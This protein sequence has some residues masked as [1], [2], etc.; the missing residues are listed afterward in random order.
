LRVE[1][2]ADQTAHS[3]ARQ[4]TDKGGSAPVA[5]TNR[6]TQRRTGH[7]ANSSTTSS[8]RHPS[9]LSTTGQGNRADE[10]N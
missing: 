1:L 9:L 3:C 6:R 10:H 4:S 2:G 7:S 8:V 5:T